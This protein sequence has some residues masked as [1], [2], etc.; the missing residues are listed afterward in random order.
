MKINDCYWLQSKQ[1]NEQRNDKKDELFKNITHKRRAKN[2]FNNNFCSIG[3]DSESEI[4][5]N[6][7]DPL[8]YTNIDLTS[9]LWLNPTNPLDLEKIINN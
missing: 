8:F 6:T 1:Y 4:P 3:N 9:S 2:I 7:L 5:N